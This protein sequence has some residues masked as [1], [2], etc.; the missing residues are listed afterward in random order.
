MY[1]QNTRR[2]SLDCGN[3]GTQGIGSA[4]K[5]ARLKQYGAGATAAEEHGPR[6]DF[7]F[8]D[9]TGFDKHQPNNFSALAASFSNDKG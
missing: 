9:Q 1:G 2:H 8:V 4:A 6:Y 7:V 5:P 3:Q